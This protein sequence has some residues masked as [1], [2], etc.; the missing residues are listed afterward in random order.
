M[1]L[2]PEAR[3]AY[4]TAIVVDLIA[5]LWFIVAYTK[6]KPVTGPHWMNVFIGDIEVARRAM[7]SVF[8]VEN[9][10]INNLETYRSIDFVPKVSL[11]P[12]DLGM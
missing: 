11:P 9:E 12:E 3:W 1:L 6:V 7:W 8:R 4:W 10:N 5:R 2:P